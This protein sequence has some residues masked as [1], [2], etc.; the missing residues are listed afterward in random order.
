MSKLGWGYSLVLGLTTY[1]HHVL[2]GEVVH[3]CNLSSAWEME[4]GGP[5]GK[6]CPQLSRVGGQLRTNETLSLNKRTN[7]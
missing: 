5:G 3:T 1:P 6:N 7:K 4:A 2:S